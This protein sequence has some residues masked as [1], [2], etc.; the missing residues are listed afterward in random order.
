MW[1]CS[2]PSALAMDI[3]QSYIIDIVAWALVW[4]RTSTRL[5]CNSI[6]TLCMSMQLAM[7]IALTV[8]GVGL[9]CELVYRD[10]L[11]RDCSV[12]YTWVSETSAG[13]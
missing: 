5:L 3:L 8:G 9:I 6:M 2:I 1:D 13:V 7:C 4:C 10:G 12:S 11:M